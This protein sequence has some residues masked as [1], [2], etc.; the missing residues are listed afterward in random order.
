[1]TYENEA[2]QGI[3]QS[4]TRGGELVPINGSGALAS[5]GIGELPDIVRRAGSRR[6]T[7]ACI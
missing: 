5:S 2:G 6:A 4:E 7:S 1:M 3:E